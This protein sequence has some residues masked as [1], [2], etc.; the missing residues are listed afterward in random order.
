MK[1]NLAAL[2]YR[3]TDQ[4]KNTDPQDAKSILVKCFDELIHSIGVFH[5]NLIPNPDNFRIKSSSF[6]RALTI[7]YTL[8]TLKVK[9]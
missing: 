6:S 3:N 8:Q 1:N 2:Q 5:D 4:M 7:I 9:H